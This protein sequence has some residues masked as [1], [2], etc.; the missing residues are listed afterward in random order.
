MRLCDAKTVAGGVSA[1]ELM[2][3]AGRAVS[4]CAD[5]NGKTAIICG[6]GN[7]GG[8]GYATALELMK[9]GLR[10]FLFIAENRFS[11]DGAYYFNL[12][13]QYKIPYK[14]FDGNTDFTDF[15]TVVDCL[16]GT[17]YNRPVEGI[18]AE[19]IE[20][21]N[22]S[23]AY[24]ISADIPSGLNGDNGLGDIFVKSDLTVSIGC[25]K[26]GHFLN[27]AKDAV[28]K[29]INKEIGI[30]IEN[31]YF[32]AEASDFGSFVKPRNNFCNKGDFGYVAVI[33]GCARYSG[34]V[35]L[36]AL[37]LAALKTG[38]G[39]S[40]I[41]VPEKIASAVMPYILE[42]TLCPVRGNEDGSMKFDGKGIAEALGG[43]KAVAVGMGWGRG[44]DNRK[45][46]AYILKNFSLPV[47]IDAD[48]LNALAEDL[49]PLDGTE[50]GV[51]IT[52]HVKEMSRLCGKSI[53]EITADPIG[54]ALEFSRKHRV[55]VA[56]KGA[57]TVVTDGKTVYIVNTGCAGMATAGSG[58]VL[59]GI[60][61]GVLGYSAENLPL[62]V[63]YATYIN[64]KAGEFA[65][66]EKTDICMTASDTVSHIFEAVIYC[67]KAVKSE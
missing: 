40:K 37:S 21:I 60:L 63:A 59:S 38:C 31:S 53:A 64:G 34:A 47:V 32:L 9:R 62:S 11:D 16:F 67:R 13:R 50:C 61:V 5:F 56:L 54:C 20:K 14:Y 30:N 44:G 24:I 12:C 35:K 18:Y 15:D 52:P 26:T 42:S 28:G 58:D 8:D 29:I 27:R 51:V 33:G 57:S 10:P 41:V 17:G 46:L 65:Q 25:L 23:H 4:L 66:K 49:T 22:K 6:A 2:A 36:A 55:T 19:I 45:I 39:V 3:R 48:G 7:N 43:V 1:R